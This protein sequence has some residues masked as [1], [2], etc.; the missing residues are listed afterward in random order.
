MIYLIACCKKKERGRHPARELYVSSLF[1]KSLCYAELNKDCERVFVLSAKYGLVGIDE[2]IEYYDLTLN[3]MRVAEI[4]KW[5]SRVVQ[6]M[7]YCG[8]LNNSYRFCF[9]AGMNYINPIKAQY[10]KIVYENPMEGMRIGKR[11]RFLNE[12][13]EKLKNGK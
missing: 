3:N 13:I 5:G 8:I 1:R 4:K 2:E 7:K 11:L 6:Q 9:L 10:S 12:S